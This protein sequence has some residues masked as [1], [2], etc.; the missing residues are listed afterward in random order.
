MFKQTNVEMKQ[1]MAKVSKNMLFTLASMAVLGSV[2]SL[3]FFFSPADTVRAGAS[4]NV[5]GFA[6]SEIGGWVSFN[7]TNCDTNDN[8]FVDSG[9]CGGNDNAS[10]PV[11]DYGVNV[12]MSGKF[13]G[14]A[15]ST[16]VGWISFQ[17]ADVAVCG[18]PTATLNMSTHEVTGW[19]RVVSGGGSNN[20]CIEFKT[21]AH[22][23]VTAS[24]TVSE[25]EGYAWAPDVLGWIS[26]NCADRGVCGTSNYAVAF[27]PPVPPPVVNLVANPSSVTTGSNSYLSWSASDGSCI[28]LE[29][30]SWVATNPKPLN[31]TN[32]PTAPLNVDTTFTLRCTGLGGTTDAST[33]VM[34]VP[35]QCQ[36]GSDQNDI[37]EPVP[38]DDTWSDSD[39]PS[40][41]DYTNSAFDP[42]NPAPW[43]DGTK[44]EDNNPQCSDGIDNDGDG[45]IDGADG[46]CH[47]DFNPSNPL[48]YNK[49]R[50]GEETCNVPTSESTPSCDLDEETFGS[51][52]V[53]CY[54]QYKYIQF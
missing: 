2:F 50:N 53:D 32:E 31:G 40:C 49:F 22:G 52:P 21:V 6:W 5:F 19:A 15:W 41:Y 26:F 54:D 44:D 7:S 28:A 48:T 38:Q 24:T 35:P 47:S 46:G 23:G 4:H 45:K 42:M 29:P 37:D 43:Y 18:S 25:F 51:C 39:D 8:G 30:A 20:G 36:D 11:H 33:T 1:G 34:I 16:I 10:T 17:D 12:D 3:T 14:Y 27:T 13:S 9:N